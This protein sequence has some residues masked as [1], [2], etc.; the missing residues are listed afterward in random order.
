MWARM[1]RPLKL[2]LSHHLSC[3]IGKSSKRKKPDDSGAKGAD[4]ETSAMP[5]NKKPRLEVDAESRV[6]KP[7]QDKFKNVPLVLQRTGLK[8]LSD[9]TKQAP[10][11]TQPVPP[12]KTIDA[13]E[14]QMP[15][16]LTTIREKSKL[17]DTSQ[18]LFKPERPPTVL[19]QKP[20]IVQRQ[21]P[22]KL[23]H[24]ED[25]APQEYETNQFQESATANS[26]PHV[27]SDESSQDFEEVPPPT[28]FGTQWLDQYMPQQ[29]Y[30]PFGY[31][32]YYPPHPYF[33]ANQ[34][35]Q[36]MNNRNFSEGQI[37]ESDL[38]V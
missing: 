20:S 7:L 5:P 33:P 25:F 28:Q 30:P 18:S 23:T 34:F 35:Y 1:V 8:L 26:G 17:L 36:N 29:F 19:A 12:Q 3:K 22:S 11:S 37:A 24:H 9:K 4:D 27:L 31:Y 13:P 14:Q 15:R 10:I 2:L 6:V 38:Y 32:G 21:P 16:Y